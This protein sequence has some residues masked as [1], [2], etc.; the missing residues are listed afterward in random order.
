MQDS[1][2]WIPVTVQLDD[3]IKSLSFNN[4]NDISKIGTDDLEYSLNSDTDEWTLESDSLILAKIEW[5]PN[6]KH[7]IK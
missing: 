2:T 6:F 3:D 1:S 7:V 4:E 5:G